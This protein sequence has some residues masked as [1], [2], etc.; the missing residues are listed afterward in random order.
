MFCQKKLIQKLQTVFKLSVKV[1]R[2][3]IQLYLTQ[4]S[5][6]LYTIFLHLDNILAKI[7][8][9]SPKSQLEEL[10]ALPHTP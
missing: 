1:V 4:K 5:V 9:G 2:V 6:K 8:G 10:T 3:I 7:F